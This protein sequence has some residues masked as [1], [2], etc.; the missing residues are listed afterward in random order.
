MQIFTAQRFLFHLLNVHVMFLCPSPVCAWLHQPN[1]E[2]AFP[3][4]HIRRCPHPALVHHCVWVHHWRIHR[5]NHRWGVIREDG[6]V[7]TE[8]TLANQSC[9]PCRGSV[10]NAVLHFQ[11]N[12]PVGQQ[13]ICINSCSAAGSELPSRTVWITH[14][15][16]SFYWNKCRWII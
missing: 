2:G 13:H 3:N 5:S 12:D 1:L 11:E 7:W 15:R 6:E 10:L 8:K 9:F 16:A 14:H 4:R